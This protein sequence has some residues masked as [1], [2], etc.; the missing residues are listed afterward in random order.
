MLID[1]HCHLDDKKY[2]EDLG[3]VLERAAAAGV[4]RM[5]S[6]GTGDGPPE[7]DRAVRLA[8]R[9]PQICASVG[10]H[11]HD[12]SK[13]T[14]QSADD[15]RAL[16]GDEKVAA[17]G[18]IGLD[19]H[20]DFS[21]R[22]TQREVFIEQLRIAAE[23]GLPVIIHTREAWEDTLAILRGHWRGPG[24]M[25]CFTGD[26]ARAREALDLGFHLAFGGVITFRTAEAVREAARITPE[27]RLLVETDAP[28]L[29][30]V[31]WRGKR[32]EPAFM[33]ETAR[34][35]AEVRGVTPEEIASITTT[36]FNRL[37]LRPRNVNRYTNVS[38]GN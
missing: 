5:L 27:D 17:F 31:P 38:D 2:A 26:A 22:E 33:T 11:P 4:M 3:G 34:K 35:L 19:Y 20:Y 15:L 14:R 13:F 25:H 36:N 21:P 24:I 12:A 7:L 37:C 6:I 8:E 23:A 9:Y 32:N 29:A 1:S 28:Y 10:V 30:P 16:A 18:E